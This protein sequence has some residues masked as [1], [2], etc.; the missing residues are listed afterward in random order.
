MVSRIDFV[1]GFW[2]WLEAQ[3]CSA[4][5]L[6]G[7]EGMPEEV[8][9]DIDFAVSGVAPDL[10]LELLARYS[11]ESGWNLVQVIEHERDALYAVC[12]QKG[13][14]LSSVVLDVTWDYRR[15]GE[16]FIDNS[17]IFEECWK[18]E[19]KNFYVPAPEVEFLYD[20]VKSASKGR[21]LQEMKERLEPLFQSAR[22]SCSKL[23]G[24]WVEVSSGGSEKKTLS[25]WEEVERV[26]ESSPAVTRLQSARKFGMNELKLYKRRVWEPTGLIVSYPSGLR[27]ESLD[28]ITGFLKDAF[29][30]IKIAPEGASW[31]KRWIIKRKSTL[32]LVPEKSGGFVDVSLNIE[33]DFE[34]PGGDQES[35]NMASQIL[36]YMSRRVAR[37]RLG[38]SSEQVTAK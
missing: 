11:E 16:T 29:R 9:S 3:G 33:S 32:L 31:L 34:E 20:F 21:S 7:W 25:R 15:K 38:S 13:G 19:T 10:Y 27:K 6:H 2:P 8:P 14:D 4:L 35:R 36:E 12:Y 30:W 28:Q 24:E 17:I 26:Y 18:P 23:L 5:I 1:D 37:Q 22:N